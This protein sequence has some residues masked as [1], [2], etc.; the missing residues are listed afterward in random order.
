MCSKIQLIAWRLLL[1]YFIIETIELV[2]AHDI[3][4]L[5][6]SSLFPRMFVYYFWKTIALSSTGGSVRAVFLL[7]NFCVNGGVFLLLYI[8]AILLGAVFSNKSGKLAKI[9]RLELVI[10]VIFCLIDLAGCIFSVPP[11][12]HPLFSSVMD[13]F[14]IL[15]SAWSII[16]VNQSAFNQTRGP[17]SD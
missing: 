5:L 17:F 13:C 9:I 3:D 14:I 4:I 12:Y 15:L 8:P 16:M 6:Q 11:H 2:T 7:M 10:V 1:G